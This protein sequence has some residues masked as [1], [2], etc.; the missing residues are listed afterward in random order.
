M[1]EWA[2]ND[3]ITDEQIELLYHTQEIVYTSVAD[4]IQDS[5][6]ILL[7]GGTTLSRCYLNHRISF[8]LDFAVRPNL[9]EIEKFHPEIE[10]LKFVSVEKYNFSEDVYHTAFYSASLNGIKV[11]FSFIEDRKYDVFSSETRQMGDIYIKCADLDTLYMNKIRAVMG[12]FIGGHRCKFR[13]FFDIFVLSKKYKP[14]NDFIDELK[15][16]KFFFN[17]HYLFDAMANFDW[18]SVKDDLIVPAKEWQNI[19]FSDNVCDIFYDE[20]GFLPPQ[21]DYWNIPTP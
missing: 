18:Y 2:K 9:H 13:D 14:I 17:E 15:R 8:D 1:V 7:I 10:K 5:D 3:Y 20:M 6:N 11:E 19:V 4:I 21:E 16:T 12:D